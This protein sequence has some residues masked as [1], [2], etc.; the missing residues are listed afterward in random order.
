[1]LNTLW[2]PHCGGDSDGSVSAVAM[3]LVQATLHAPRRKKPASVIT[4]NVA[5]RGLKTSGA[6][7]FELRFDPEVAFARALADPWRGERPRRALVVALGCTSSAA[8]LLGDGFW[9]TLALVPQMVEQLVLGLQLVDESVV[10]CEQKT[11]ADGRADSGHSSS[12]G[13]GRT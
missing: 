7:N 4:E 8:P 6:E 10:A 9:D 5:P 12:A 2:A 3:A 11:G 1:M 13:G